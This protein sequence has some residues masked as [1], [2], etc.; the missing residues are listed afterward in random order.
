MTRLAALL[1]VALTAAALAAPAHAQLPAPAPD[2]V[3]P[4]GDPAPGSDAWK[5]RDR[6]N[7]YCAN[8]RL[9]D[10]YAN[11]AFG[12]AFGTQTPGIFAGQNVEMLKDPAHPHA[13]LAQ[14]V[15]GGSTTDPFRTTAR[16]TAAGRGRVDAISFPADDGA[17]LNGLL[18][19]PP[20]SVA[21]PVPRRRDHHRLDPGLPADVLLG[22]RGPRRGGLRGADLRRPGPGQ[23]RHVPGDGQLH[24]AEL[25]QR[26]CRSSRPTT[27]TRA[28]RTR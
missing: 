21:G 16:W 11:P 19:R 4:A 28:P 2:C 26:A 10:E 20:A 9:Q 15:P 13:T 1:T 3:A 7:M 18:F 5:Q 17:K 12:F 22:R 27:S 8:E 25:V 23:L 6:D 24:R 14:L